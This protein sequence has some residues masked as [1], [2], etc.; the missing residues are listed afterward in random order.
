MKL[1]TSPCPRCRSNGRDNRGDNLANYPDGSSHCFSCHFHVFPKHYVPRKIENHGPKNLLPRDFTR[2]VPASALKW[3]LQY[4]LPWSYWKETIGYS[5]SEE[6]L[7]FLVGGGHRGAD[8]GPR[9]SIGR[10]VGAGGGEAP[11][12]RKWFVWGDSH[13]HAEIVGPSGMALAPDGTVKTN[14]ILVEDIVS[15]HKIVVAMQDTAT[16]VSAIPLFGTQIHKPHLYYLMNQ[17]AGSNVVL[18]LDKDQQGTIMRKAMGLQALRGVRVATVST[19]NDPKSL[20]T[21]EIKKALEPL[22]KE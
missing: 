21:Q 3:L 2:E 7:V 19:D 11:K 16:P 1:W 6:R 17:P 5:P 12:P 15:A 22:I 13:R 4:G 14:T 9:F 18:W 20:S 8:D 10:Y